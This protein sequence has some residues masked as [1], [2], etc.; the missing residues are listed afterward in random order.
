M[1]LMVVNSLGFFLTMVL[2]GVPT[3]LAISMA[4]FGGFVS[5][6]IPAIGAPHCEEVDQKVDEAD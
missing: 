6:F 1:I 4:I 3:T 5:V 2:V